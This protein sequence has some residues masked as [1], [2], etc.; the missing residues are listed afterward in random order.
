[1]HRC[2]AVCVG[3]I[4]F[5]FLLFGLLAALCCAVCRGSACCDLHD[6]NSCRQRTLVAANPR[7]QR[8]GQPVP[9]AVH[10]DETVI[11]QGWTGTAGTEG[12][13]YRTSRDRRGFWFAPGL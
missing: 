9:E 13:I 11:S 6:D 4:L 12:V 1:M 8:R 7:E 5:M 10:L 3:F 2:D